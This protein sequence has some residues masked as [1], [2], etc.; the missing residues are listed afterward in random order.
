MSD[1]KNCAR[2]GA[3][4]ERNRKLSA[5]QWASRSFCSK[6]CAATKISVSAEVV[7]AHY[8]EGKSSTEL[9]AQFGVDP[10]SIRRIIIKAGGQLRSLS[11]AIS[12][13]HNRAEFKQACAVR[14]TGKRLSEGAKQK[15]RS[16]CGERSPKWKGGITRHRDGYEI[17]SNA[18]GNGDNAGKLVHRLIAEKK[19]GRKLLPGEHVHHIDFNKTNNH[20]DNLQVMDAREHHILHARAS[21]FGRRA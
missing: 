1:L 9:G 18:I 21:G 17:Y 16:L 5:K 10:H 4:F 12:I 13:S 15:L 20:P 11:E 8:S 19:I 3:Q 14:Q 7:I 2:C 6:K